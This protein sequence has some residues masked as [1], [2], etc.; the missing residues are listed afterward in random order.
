M[1]ARIAFAAVLLFVGLEAAALT[2]DADDMAAI[3]DIEQRLASAWLKG[4]RAFIDAILAPDWSVIDASGRTL[5]K[6]Q[7]IDETFGS[8]DRRIESMVV[9]D[10]TVRMFGDAAVATGR[11]RASGRYHGEATSVVLRFTD[12]FVRRS[13]RWLIV[14]SHASAVAP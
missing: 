10:V 4:D 14:A 11:T 12:V 6:R 8:G 9:D 3:A 5:G 2:Q 13:G 7:V 1:T